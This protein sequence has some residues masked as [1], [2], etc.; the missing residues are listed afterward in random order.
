MLGTTRVR[1]E[2]RRGKCSA[3][4]LVAF[5][6][7]LHLMRTYANF[8]CSALTPRPHPH[9]HC[10]LASSLLVSHP[11]AANEMHFTFVRVCFMFIYCF[12]YILFNE[13][14]E[15]QQN[16]AHKYVPENIYLVI[17][18]NILLIWFSFCFPGLSLMCL[19]KFG[20]VQHL[21]MRT[22][23]A[24]QNRISTASPNSARC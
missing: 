10:S 15:K 7:F 13:T 11:D 17:I 22:A 8:H 1:R 24:Q 6:W 18:F 4:Q 9:P 2:M 14:T 19:V 23:L 5:L 3:L 16:R 21:L 12:I 20:F